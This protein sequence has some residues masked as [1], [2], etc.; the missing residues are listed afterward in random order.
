M[1]VKELKNAQLFSTASF[2]LRMAI[3]EGQ[4]RDQTDISLIS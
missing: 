1:C 2:L 3:S 4:A